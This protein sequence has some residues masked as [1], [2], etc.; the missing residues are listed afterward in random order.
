MTWECAG[1]LFTP[2]STPLFMYSM[3]RVH[4]N[5][6]HCDVSPGGLSVYT[7]LDFFIVDPA[8]KEEY[9]GYHP[10][11]YLSTGGHA[12][13]TCL[14]P[15]GQRTYQRSTPGVCTTQRSTSSEGRVS[16]DCPQLRDILHTNIICSW[17][18]NILQ[19]NLYRIHMYI[20]AC[21]TMHACNIRAT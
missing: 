12:W 2:T 6:H 11:A 1:P 5:T 16:V 14:P 20:M 21:E 13:R 9:E 3:M 8:A 18:I 19:T 10:D 7:D 17:P 4:A 15:E